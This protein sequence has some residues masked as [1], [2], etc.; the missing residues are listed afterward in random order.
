MKRPLWERECSIAKALTLPV[1]LCIALGGYAGQQFSP[2]SSGPDSGSYG[3]SVDVDLVVLHATVSDRKGGFVS[4]LRDQDFEIYE[5]GVPQRIRLFRHEDIPVTVGLV[6]DHS[7]SM[8]PKIAEVTAAA[9][10]FV[11]SSNPDDQMFVVNFNEK[12]TL[13]LPEAIQFTDS[14]GELE[15]A[16]SNA[17]AAGQTAL[18]DAI[19]KALEQSQAGSRDKKVLIVI[20]DGGDNASAQSLA[21][22]LKMAEQFSAIIYAI[23][24]FQEDDPDANPRVLSRLAQATGGEAF[25][26]HQPSEVVAICESIARDIRNQYTIGY[27]PTNTAR[28][29]AYRTIRAVAR[30]TGHGKLSVRTRAWYIAS[31]K[32]RA[33]KDG[34]AK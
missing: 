28:D 12:V 6:V 34:P 27:V 9:R 17:P 4:D 10:T 3:I 7:G 18:Y 15:R 24:I 23:G 14:S 33:S 30:A 25:F 8:R 1:C 29:G 31:S 2:P 16:I 20:S 19:G 11:Q 22:V 13:G 32:P 5:D 26:P 21:H